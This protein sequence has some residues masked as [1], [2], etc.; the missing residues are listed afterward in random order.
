[1][2]EGPT[3][4]RTVSLAAGC[5]VTPRRTLAVVVPAAM[6]DVLLPV[7]SRPRPQPVTVLSVNRIGSTVHASAAVPWMSG[8]VLDEVAYEHGQLLV[9][10]LDGNPL[11]PTDVCPQQW[12]SSALTERRTDA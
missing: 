6:V 5:T 11:A 3:L 10:V 7:R 1:M 2:R 9:N 12:R 8:V 4:N